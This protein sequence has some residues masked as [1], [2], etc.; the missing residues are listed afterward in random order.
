[1]ATIIY[2][3]GDLLKRQRFRTGNAAKSQKTIAKYEFSFLLGLGMILCYYFIVNIEKTKQMKKNTIKKV[4]LFTGLLLCSVSGVAL[5]HQVAKENAPEFNQTKVVIDNKTISIQDFYDNLHFGSEGWIY[6]TPEGKKL[7]VDS[8][9]NFHHKEQRKQDALK[10]LKLKKQIDTI[11]VSYAQNELKTLNKPNIIFTKAPADTLANMPAMGRCNYD[12]IVIR[13]FKADNPELQEKMNR[14]NDCLNGTYVHEEQHFFNA[15]NGIRTWN[16][17]PLKYAECC[18]D[19][20]SANIRQCLKQ[21]QNYLNHGRDLKYITNRFS[22][23]RE[24]LETGKFYP[25]PG[26]ISEEEAGFIANAV[27][28]SWMKEKYD[29]YSKQVYSRSKYFLKDA[30]YPAILED[31]DKHNDIMKMIFTIDG[32]DFWKTLS[33][34]EAE[35]FARITPEMKKNW[36]NLSNEKFQKMGYLEKLEYKKITEGNQTYQNTLNKNV[37]KAKLI[38]MFNMD[39]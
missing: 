13:E 21:R 29:M 16:S 22:F 15:Q 27:F 12:V 8:L 17:Y 3:K 35:I 31:K 26:K 36:E 6:T 14:Y 33:K 20:I 11:Y 37:L 19:E 4:G 9:C 18:F 2:Q 38:S 34:R 1:M 28:D 24:A 30:P 10:N 25:Q 39:K 7:N 5:M 23:Y 32:V